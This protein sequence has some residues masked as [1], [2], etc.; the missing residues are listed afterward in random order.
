[1]E[2]TISIC[3]AEISLQTQK[4]N[5]FTASFSE[6]LHSLLHT[7]QETARCQV[8]LDEAKAKLR[9]TEDD[10]VKALAVKTRREAKRMALVDAIASTKARV[11]ELDASIQERRTK[12]Q[13]YAAIISQ[14]S[15]DLTVSEGELNESVEQKDETQEVISWYNT[16]LG[17][18]VKGGR[19]VKFT[20]KNI[21]MNNP[22]EEYFFTILHGKDTYSLLSCEP[23]LGK[24]KELIHE[25]NNT[26][27]LFKFVRV[28]RKKFQEAVAQGSLVETAG[29]HEES[30]FNS[31]SAPVLS[32]SSVR[33]DFPGKE[34]EH[35]VEPTEGNTKVGKKHVN[36]RLK[37]VLSPGSASSVRQS[38]RLKARK[39]S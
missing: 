32:M 8:Q 35:Q 13:A 38:P 29:E 7:V 34:N 15:L 20:F 27:D 6:S 11:E 28:M 37:A 1:M 39:E 12:K 33:S 16:V 24:T 17:F 31:T 19:G 2:S 26:N 9:D 5:A 30:A 10:F 18:H 23:S 21:N 14:Q 22:H 3:D 25:L 36:R 4:I